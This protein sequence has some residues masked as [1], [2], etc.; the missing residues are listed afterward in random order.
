MSNILWDD[1][2]S[3]FSSSSVTSTRYAYFYF[4]HIGDWID[5]CTTFTNI[6][7]IRIDKRYIV[8]CKGTEKYKINTKF[9][10]KMVDK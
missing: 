4:H 7:N 6:S 3:Y 2:E 1:G 8:K 5:V 10:C 9:V